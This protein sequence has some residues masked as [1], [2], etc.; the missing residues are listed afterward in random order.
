[1]PAEAA[2]DAAPR[3]RRTQAER[4]TETRALLLDAALAQLVADGLARFTTTE[5]GRRSG[6]SQGALFKHFPSK[7]E[8]LAAVA[9]HLFDELRATYEEA[10]HSLPPSR[11]TVRDGLDLLWQHMLDP[12]LAAAFELYTAARTDAELRARLEPVVRAHV[13]RVEELAA[14]LVDLGDP[15]RLRAACALAIAAMQG[16][17]L[18]QLALPAPDQIASLRAQLHA[19]VPLFLN[20]PAHRPEDHHG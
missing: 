2:L 9:E 7:A 17:V 19:L 16:L 12:R 1:M 10:F 3:A 13:A 6:L 5:V 20:A 15:A 14:S 18:N 11:R 8:L 4:R